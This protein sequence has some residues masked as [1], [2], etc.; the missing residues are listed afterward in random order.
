MRERG[1]LGTL[2]ASITSQ[3]AVDE[4]LI[5]VTPKRRPRQTILIPQPTVNEDDNL[6]VISI[7]EAAR[8]KR[9]S[10]AYSAIVWKLPEW[11]VVASAS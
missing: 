9:K 5:A 4:M 6:M 2:A 11:T 10:V 3:T 7:D 8:L 1:R